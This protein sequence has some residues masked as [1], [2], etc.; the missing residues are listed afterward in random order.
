MALERLQKIISRSG[1]TSRRKAEAWIVE[2]RVSVDGKIVRELGSKADWS[3][4]NIKV[5]GQ[6]VRPPARM[7]YLALHKPRGY[8]T[9]RSD[10]ERRSTVMDLIKKLKEPVYPVG[11]LDYHSEGLLLLT[12]DGDFANRLTSSSSTILKTYWVKVKGL[13]EEK[14]IEKLRQGVVLD[15]RRTLPAQIRLLRNTGKTS[16]DAS[17]NSWYEVVIGEGRQN[18]IRRMFEFIEHPVQKLKRVQI[19]PLALGNLPLGQ[20]RHLTP[21]EVRRLLGEKPTQRVIRSP[22]QNRPPIRS[23]TLQDRPRTR[24]SAIKNHRRDQTSVREDR[25]RTRPNANQDRPRDRPSE[26][27]PRTRAATGRNRPPVERSRDHQHEKNIP[28]RG[29]RRESFRPKQL[30]RPIDSAAS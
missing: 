21:L 26:N 22:I 19:G 18:Q 6:P 10:P 13:P 14:D 2:G 1:L 3:T 15:R 24:S 7:I 12:N 29:K 27:R 16:R 28:I 23:A 11:R 17:A 20:A 9:T 8:V 25:P 30:T 5:D 4:A